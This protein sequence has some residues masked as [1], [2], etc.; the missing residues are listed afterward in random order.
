MAKLGPS[1]RTLIIT[2]TSIITPELLAQRTPTRVQEETDG[3]D[4]AGNR[5]SDLRQ[6]IEPLRQWHGSRLVMNMKLLVSLVKY[7]LIIADDNLLM[8]CSRIKAAGVRRA[9]CRRH[10]PLQSVSDLQ[11]GLCRNPILPLKG[12]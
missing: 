11:P 8:S 2:I 12:L 6:R 3:L 10:S 5:D 9:W 1:I 7:Y 4:P